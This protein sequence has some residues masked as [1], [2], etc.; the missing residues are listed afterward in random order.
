MYL[1]DYQLVY[2]P[3]WGIKNH[4]DYFFTA[5]KLLYCSKSNR[6][7][8]KRVKGGLSVGYTIDGGFIIL[9]KLRPLLFKLNKLSKN[10]W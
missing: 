10:I 9:S 4:P 6:V 1:I 5:D 8:K 2:I 3:K 7:I